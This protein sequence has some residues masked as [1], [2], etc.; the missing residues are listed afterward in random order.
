MAP[1][2]Q[3]DTSNSGADRPVLAVL[4]CRCKE[5]VASAETALQDILKDLRRQLQLPSLDYKTV[6]NQGEYLIEVPT[7]RTD[8][9]KV[10]CRAGISHSAAPAPASPAWMTS[11]AN[12]QQCL[13]LHAR[14]AAARLSVIVHGSGGGQDPLQRQ[15]PNHVVLPLHQQ[16]VLM[17]RDSRHDITFAPCSAS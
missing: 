4:L 12:M 11:M 10:G 17:L 5:D 3:A 14:L 9:P 13:Q 16:S 7:E 1:E 15:H 2:V 8:V 6:Q